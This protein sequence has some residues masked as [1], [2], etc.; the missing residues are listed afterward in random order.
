MVPPLIPSSCEVYFVENLSN[1]V[2]VKLTINFELERKVF[3]SHKALS[4]NSE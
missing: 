4:N 3:S 1:H 2:A